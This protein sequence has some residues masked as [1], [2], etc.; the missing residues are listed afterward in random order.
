M[1]YY[2]KSETDIIPKFKY[3]VDFRQ[4]K[5]GIYKPIFKLVS[6]P[7]VPDA[8]AKSLFVIAGA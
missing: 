7:E 4:K 3:C 1:K 8:E 5:R 6:D 2:V